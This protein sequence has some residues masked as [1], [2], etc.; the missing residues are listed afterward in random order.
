MNTNGDDTN[1]PLTI[2]G[3]IDD[4]V[5]LT[6]Y[7]AVQLIRTRTGIPIPVSRFRKDSANGLTPKPVLVYGRT[8]L[9]RPTEIMVY[10][11]TLVRPFAPEA[12]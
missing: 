3:A 4:E 8:H 9:Y 12:A 11:K 5:L 6:V 10:A 7:A 2:N 1:A